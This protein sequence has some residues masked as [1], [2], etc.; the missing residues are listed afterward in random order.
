MKFDGIIFDLDG[1]L[2]DSRAAVCESW[3]CVLRRDYPQLR[4]PT[5]EEFGR[6]MGKLLVDI[7]RS[8]F[9]EL[10]DEE[11]DVLIRKCCDYENEYLAG[12]GGILF[13]GLEDTLAKLAEKYKLIIVSNCQSGYIE[14]FFESHGLSKYFIDRSCSGDTGMLKADN[15]KL[16]IE[17]NGLKSPVYVGDT[18]LDGT[19]AAEAGIPFIWASYGFGEPERCDAKLGSITELPALCENNNI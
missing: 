3:A 15:I 1:T 10:N 4:V 7:G 11:N 17:R 9:P 6:Q 12:H 14:A 16:V 19:S 18:A 5:P 8:L 13:D 2:W